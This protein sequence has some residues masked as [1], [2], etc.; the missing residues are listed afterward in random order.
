MFDYDGVIVDSLEIFRENLIRACKMN[1][2]NQISEGN[3]LDLFNG[4]KIGRAHV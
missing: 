2:C 3:F 1:G 4:N